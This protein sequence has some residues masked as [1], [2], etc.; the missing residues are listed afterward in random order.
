MA[1]PLPVV[2]VVDDDAPV[3]KSLARLVKIAG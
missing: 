3:R 2:F 1:P